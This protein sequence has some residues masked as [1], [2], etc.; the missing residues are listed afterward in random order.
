[1]SDKI[2]PVP[3]QWAAGAHINAAS[4]KS[5]YEQSVSDPA[6]FWGEQGKRLDWI[7]PYTKVKNT[8]FNPGSVDIRWFE[9]GTLN[10]S[11]NCI[12][13]H[14]AKRADQ[15]AIIWEGD[16]PNESEQITYRQLSERVQRFANVLK[17]HGVKRGDR[18]TI[19]LPMIPEAAYAMLACSRVGAIHSIVFGGFSPDSLQNRVE[20]AE[21]KLVITA[22][23]SMRGGKAVPLKKNA[24]IALEKCKGDEKMLVVRRTGNPIPWKEIGRAHV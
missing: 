2:Y 21:S 23:E 3:A 11:A 9:D 13:R 5:M 16:N 10:V 20:D 7:K 18:V 6:K 19:Y 12:D 4:Y 22:D 8:S 15:V 17:K 1:M 14:L 24:D